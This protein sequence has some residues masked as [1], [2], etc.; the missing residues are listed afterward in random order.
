M[1]EELVGYDY[2]A[3]RM[4]ILV[5]SVRVGASRPNRWPGFP[6]PATPPK[7]RSPKFRKS[8]ADTFIDEHLQRRG[9]RRGRERTKGWGEPKV[10]PKRPL[11]PLRLDLSDLVGYAYFAEQLRVKDIKRIYKLASPNS[12]QHDPRF[13]RP[14]TPPSDRSPKFRRA[15]ADAYCEALKQEGWAPRAKRTGDAESSEAGS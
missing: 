12:L 3:E 6:K 14:V 10:K 13:P 9:E 2:F 7:D 11:R 15:D 8:E 5:Q 4:G 1:S